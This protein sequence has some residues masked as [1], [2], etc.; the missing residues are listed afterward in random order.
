[1]VGS[2]EEAVAIQAALATVL[3]VVGGDRDYPMR[4]GFGVRRYLEV[5]LPQERTVRATST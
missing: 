3:D 2:P 1:M 4:N 5:R